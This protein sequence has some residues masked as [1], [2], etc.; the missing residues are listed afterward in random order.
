MRTRSPH[1]SR[2]CRRS[3]LLLLGL[4]CAGA[5]QA[6][7]GVNP[8]APAAEPASGTIWDYIEPTA[9]PETA[10]V[11]DA[12]TELADERLAEI[13]FRG[14]IGAAP[15]LE[16]YLDPLTATERDPLH[17]EL[18]DPS[19]FDIPIVVNDM[20]KGWM[21]YFLGKGRKYYARYLA[22]SGRWLPMMYAELDAR[23]LPRD[24]VYLS[25]IESGF[26]PGAYSYASAAG[27]WQFMP[28]TGRQYG[29]RVDWWLDERRD[30]E[31]ATVAALAYLTYLRDMFDGKWWLAWASYNGGE[32]RVMNATR[33]YG[34]TDFWK[35]VQADTLH[36]ETENYVPKLIAAAIIGKHPER[37][38]F[39]GIEYQTAWSFDRVQVPASTSV[40]ALAK[41][42]GITEAEFLEFNPALRRYAL[43]PDPET[44]SVRIPKGRAVAFQAAFAK[45]PPA[46]RVAL[47]EHVVKRGESL[48]AIARKY[49][50]STEEIVR[51][52]RLSSANVIKV[53]QRLV[54]PVPAKGSERAVGEASTASSAS[55][56]PSSAASKPATPAP[57]RTTT[58]TVQRGDTLAAIASR[59]GATV[60]DLKKWNDIRDEN[61]IYAGQKLTLA[62][63]SGS[64][65]SG[66][67][68]SSGASSSSSASSTSSS[69]P[70]TYTVRSGDTLSGIAAKHGVSVAQLQS[71]NSLSGTTIAVGKVLVVAGGSAPAAAGKTTIYTVRRGDTLGS[72]AERYNCTVSELKSLNGLSGAT[73]YVGQKLKIK[74]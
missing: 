46:E 23:G 19:E 37:Y 16:Y 54:V 18:V 60:A 68:S 20:V 26:S 25:M 47:T 27:L 35:I 61:A 49:G 10:E 33:R 73:I 59:H 8:D 41:C 62:A 2:P 14:D 51:V 66:S 21:N 53:G 56:A 28:A 38:G 58:Y 44:Q 70:R 34:T 29:L 72:I 4:A 31:K 65:A 15:P 74:E 22:R 52:N 39:V 55:S 5:A 63:G 67:S 71:W 12:T 3:V 48:G 24:L 43:P 40:E 1:R 32:G 7:E 45:L 57:T 64:A 11:I 17:L 42:A 69:A 50:V 9:P 30:P 36:S 6:A 13:S